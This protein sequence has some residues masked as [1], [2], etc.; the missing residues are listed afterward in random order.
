MVAQIWMIDI[1]IFFWLGSRVDLIDLYLRTLHIS[2][3]DYNNIK[4]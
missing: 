4:E 1:F 3:R 2:K